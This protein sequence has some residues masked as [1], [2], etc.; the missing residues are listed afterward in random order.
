VQRRIFEPKRN[1]IIGGWR[2][3]HKEELHNLY[4]SPNIIINN[5]QVKEYEIGR[6]FRTHGGGKAGRKEI[7]RKTFMEMGG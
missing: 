3:L 6:A 7:I 1:Y 5:D 4:S 2:K